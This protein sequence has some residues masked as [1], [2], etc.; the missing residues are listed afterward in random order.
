MTVG[1]VLIPISTFV[2]GVIIKTLVD[3]DMAAVIVKHWPKFL[4]TRF[5]TRR[6]YH[7]LQGTWEETWYTAN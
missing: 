3:L 6:R 5:A 1:S 2:I 7:N 4:R